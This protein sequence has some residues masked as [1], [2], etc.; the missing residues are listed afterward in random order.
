MRDWVRGCPGKWSFFEG[1]TGSQELGIMIFTMMFLFI[2]MRGYLPS[3]S[4]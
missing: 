1:R 2:F 3:P 4:E